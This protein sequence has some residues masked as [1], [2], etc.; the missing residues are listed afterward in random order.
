MY[1]IRHLNQ[2]L[3]QNNLARQ[4][5][6]LAIG[7]FDGLHLGHMQIINKVI[8]IAKQKNLLSTIITFEP[9]PISLFRPKLAQNFRITSLAQKLRMLQERHIK[10]VAI[11]PFNKNF[12]NLS[13]DD[14]VKKILVDGLN[15]KEL[16]VG[17]DFIF[18]KNREGD[19]KL[20]QQKAKNYGFYINDI[21]AFKNGDQIYSS[22]LIRNFIQEG[23]IKSANLALGHNFSVEA[24]VVHGQKLAGNIGF[25]TANLIPKK[26]IIMP[27]FGV[28]KA[29]VSILGPFSVQN[30][31]FLGNFDAIVNFGVK[32]TIS[33]SK[34]PI[35][36]IHIF[37]FNHDIYGRKLRV[38]LLDFIREEKK[39]PSLDALKQQI[40]IDITKSKN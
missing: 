36:E 5:S 33:G 23:K 2:I 29:K 12:A 18:G 9:H 19:I 39:F 8:E 32:P 17:Y 26:H 1:L 21:D 20:L 15:V 31:L 38:E 11:M 37:D 22:T 34:Q 40:I 7:N 6:V 35:Y 28:Y 4:A 30:Q 14:F 10:Q 13:A 3:K 27:K 16:V 25:A 24:M